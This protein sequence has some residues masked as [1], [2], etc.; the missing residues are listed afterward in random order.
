MPTMFPPESDDAGDS[1]TG[2]KQIRLIRTFLILL[3]PCLVLSFISGALYLALT[4]ST[5]ETFNDIHFWFYFFD[6][7]REIN[8]P[9]WYTSVMWVVAGLVAGYFARKAVR[10]RLSWGL[11]AFVCV[12]FSL[13]EMLELHERLDVIGVE[14]SKYLPFDLHFVWVIPGVIIAAVFVLLLLRM[15]LSL[16]AGV[17]NGLIL[18]GIVFVSGAVGAESL[19]GLVLASYEEAPPIFFAVTLLE[20]TLEMSGV[21]LC[22]SSLLHLLEHRATDG[23]TAYRMAAR[24]RRTTSEPHSFA[25]VTGA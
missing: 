10:F 25:D 4:R 6:V 16:P 19:S 15:V 8:V 22:L 14:L 1:V 20:E 13:D 21:S 3:V 17:R 7:G 11:F 9:T 12:L 5:P 24:K 23:G 2:W 18:A